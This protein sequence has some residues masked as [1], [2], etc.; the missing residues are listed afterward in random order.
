[1]KMGRNIF[2]PHLF[3]GQLVDDMF[4]TEGCPSDLFVRI[5]FGISDGLDSLEEIIW[6]LE[7]TDMR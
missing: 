1:M 5:R 3:M 4:P 6:W 2:V 7:N